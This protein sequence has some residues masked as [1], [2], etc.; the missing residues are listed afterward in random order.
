MRNK[1]AFTN[2]DIKVRDNGWGL[3][4]LSHLLHVP[5]VPLDLGSATL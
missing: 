5:T 4:H 2:D 3:R 1:R